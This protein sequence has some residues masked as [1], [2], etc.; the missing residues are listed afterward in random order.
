MAMAELTHPDSLESA[1]LD[2][3]FVAHGDL[4]ARRPGR[5]PAG[6]VRD[7]EAACRAA[8][9][10]RGAIAEARGGGKVALPAC[11]HHPACGSCL[12][13]APSIY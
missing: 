6:P 7:D 12:I 9:S 1:A 3:E 10:K 4:S 8:P 5:G 11:A 13:V 2:Y